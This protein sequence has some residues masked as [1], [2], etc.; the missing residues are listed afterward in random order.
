VAGL[1]VITDF[2]LQL[3]IFV[4]ALSLDNQRIK[5]NRSDIACLCRK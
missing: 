1:G 3:T 5:E 4:G 2:V